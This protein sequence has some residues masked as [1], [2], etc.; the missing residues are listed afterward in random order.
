MPN[1]VHLWATFILTL[2]RRGQ[3]GTPRSFHVLILKLH[4]WQKKK[5]VQ[6]Q[7]MKGKL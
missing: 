2:Q 3:Q 5:N 6:E 4:L 1:P 7:Q